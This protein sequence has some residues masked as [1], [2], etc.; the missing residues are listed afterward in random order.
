L[1]SAI[2]AATL[3]S[4]SLTGC[5]EKVKPI[6]PPPHDDPVGVRKPYDVSEDG[7][8]SGGGAVALANCTYIFKVD[9]LPDDAEDSEIETCTLLFDLAD[10]L[11]PRIQMKLTGPD[12]TS[13]VLDPPSETNLEVEADAFEGA[14]PVD[15]TWIL[16]FED[17]FECTAISSVTLNL[18]GSYFDP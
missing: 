15:G 10:E 13:Q 11:D 1:L 14:D 18:D 4:L 17:R 2:T 8:Q 3:L 9:A 6:P 5:D 16:A 12:G 7:A